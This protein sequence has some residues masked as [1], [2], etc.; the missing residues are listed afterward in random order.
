MFEKN[1]KYYADWRTP[2]GKRHRK[3]FPTPLGAK[4]HETTQRKAENPTPPER[5]DNTAQSK[6][7]KQGRSGT[8]QG[9]SGKSQPKSKSPRSGQPTLPK[10][11]TPGRNSREP[12]AT[13]TI[14][15]SGNSSGGLVQLAALT[16]QVASRGSSRLSR[17]S[18]GQPTKRPSAS[19]P[20]PISHSAGSS[21]ADSISGCAE[22]QRSGSHHAT[23]PAGE[24]SQQ[25][26]ADGPSSSQS[27]RDSKRSRN[28]RGRPTTMR[29]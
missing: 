11:S 26:S 20:V 23:S 13:A 12:R 28:S 16:S 21:P 1:G 14:A 15:N 18:S 27:P 6:P 3:A 9:D 2:D 17:A 4:R 25:P 5:S 7:Q 24:S 19:S 22:G 29:I 10:S 8:S